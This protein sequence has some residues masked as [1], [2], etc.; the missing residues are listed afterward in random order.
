MKR[1]S[2]NDVAKKVE[3]RRRSWKPVQPVPSLVAAAIR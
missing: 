1:S 2:K 3:R